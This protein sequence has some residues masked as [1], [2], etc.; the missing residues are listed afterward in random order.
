M[1]IGIIGPPSSI[2][3]IRSMTRMEDAYMECVEYP[4]SLRK[5]AELLERVQPELDGILFT[6]VRY[7]NY[8]SRH[9]SASIPWTS[10]KLHSD[11]SLFCALLRAHMTGCDITHITFDLY[12]TTTDKMM[13]ILCGQLGL[14]ADR[15]TLFRYNDTQQHQDYL[16]GGTLVGRYADGASEFHI[17][18]FRD[19]RA[20]V[21]L[22]DSPSTAAVLK[23]KGYPVFLATFTKASIV[24]ALND[25]RVR[26]QLYAQQRT[27]EHQEAVLCL[28]VEM[29]EEYGYG[30]PEFRQIQSAGR[31][32]TSVFVFAQSVGGAVEKCSGSQYL[33]FTT[34]GELD[35]ATSDLQDLSFTERILSVEDVERISIGIGFGVTHSIAKVNARQA[36][37]SA[38]QQ[39][40]SCY[41]TKAG[42]TVPK[43]P[44]LIESHQTAQE[45]HEVVL[46]RIARETNVGLTVL[47]T[48][49]R[50]QKQY[51][52]RT[53]TSSELANMTGM[54]LNNIHR[55]IVKLEAKGYAEIVG[56]QPSAEAGRPRRLIRFHFGFVPS[57]LEFY[58]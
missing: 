3:R 39:P 25:L 42:E 16:Y 41:Y 12:S 55:I 15:I 24:A 48:L 58:Q 1:K 23:E 36:N 22:T 44:F 38:R 49:V 34:K 10:P 57:N 8:A 56:H 50:A 32:E 40:Y 54:S 47:N 51:N 45:F 13:D 26:S 43:G 9:V 31:V 21:C 18:K 28:T 7:L 11:S 52:F 53:V 37:K 33:V 46:K 19:G 27:G 30:N 5:V 29:S 2:K 14:D 35:A 6:G 17:D 20:S 4:C